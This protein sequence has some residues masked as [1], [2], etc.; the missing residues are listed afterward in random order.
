MIKLANIGDDG[1]METISMFKERAFKSSTFKNSK[2][3]IIII[4]MVGD[5][6]KTRVKGGE[7]HWKLVQIMPNLCSKEEEEGEEK[8][9]DVR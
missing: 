4:Q 9:D 2:L 1:D 6:L 5:H 8:D 3:L 7:L